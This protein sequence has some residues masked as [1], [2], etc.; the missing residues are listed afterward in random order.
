[1]GTRVYVK[2]VSAYASEWDIDRFFSGFGHINS[3][4]LRPNG[5][6]YVVMVSVSV[7]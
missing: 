6:G 2:G 7:M 4:F 3:M 1:M 5:S